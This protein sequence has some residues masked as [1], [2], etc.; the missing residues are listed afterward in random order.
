MAVAAS[1][2]RATRHFQE[3]WNTHKIS[4]QAKKKL[5][6]GKNPRQLF[7]AP[8]SGRLDAKDCS[9]RV[10]PETVRRLRDGIGG[11][12]GRKK[13]NEFV[14]NEFRALADSTYVALDLPAVT[15]SNVWEIFVLGVS[16][17]RPLSADYFS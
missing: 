6:S 4:P 14:D 16:E 11:E 7:I 10:N 1:R 13:A 15:L 17:L 3:Y 8:E 9:I 2:T 12:E 5:P